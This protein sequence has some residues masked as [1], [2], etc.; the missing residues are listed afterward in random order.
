MESSMK[1]QLFTPAH[2]G[3]Q[4]YVAHLER[5]GMMHHALDSGLPKVDTTYIGIYEDIVIGHISIQKQPL[6]VPASSLTDDKP[7]ALSRNE[8]QLYET[9]VQ[10]FAVEES[11]RRRGYGRAL[12]Q[13]A[14]EQTQAMGCCQMRSW[15]SA[16]K[17]ANYGLKLSMGFGVIPALYPMPGGKPIS[18]VYFVM[19]V[20]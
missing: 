8:H 15:S 20:E 12:Q 6:I 14:L 11:H 5:S 9:F 13:S 4:A 19:Q 7:L 2:A 17:Y 10:T 18:G 16:D 1:P 3:W